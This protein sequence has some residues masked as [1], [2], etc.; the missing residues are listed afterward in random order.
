M[1]IDIKHPGALHRELGVPQGQKIPE[2]KLQ[3]ALHSPDPHRR[4][5]AQFA[6]NAKGF[7]HHGAV[8]HEINHHQTHGHGS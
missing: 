7:D 5:Q 1:S 8:Q 6:E 4:A 3:Q 2:A